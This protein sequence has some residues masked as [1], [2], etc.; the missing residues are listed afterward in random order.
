M[1]A[2]VA[3][4]LFSRFPKRT[5]QG[6]GT[7]VPGSGS[8]FSMLILLLLAALLF[9]SARPAAA[10]NLVQYASDGSRTTAYFDL[11]Q[12]F[13]N[14]KL[15]DGRFGWQN[16]S[17]LTESGRTMARVRYP[18]G[19]FNPGAV[20]QG[21]PSGGVGFRVKLGLPESD[22]M[23]ISY[24]VRFAPNFNF[25]KG[26][27]LPGLGGG[28]GN[29][30]GKIPNGSDGFSSRLMW[31]DGG[32]G[33]VYAYMPSSKE[34]GT[35]LGRGSWRFKTGVW[36]H[37]EQTLKLNTPGRSDGEVS[38]WQDGRLVFR[39]GG[40]KFRETRNLKIDLLI[41]ET[42]FGGGSPDWATPV[43]TYAD[44]ADVTVSTGN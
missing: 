27:K 3:V 22:T 36:Q 7:S 42:F 13:A 19:S 39:T 21:A 37:M 5:G 16:V 14:P 12:L 26:G 17:I 1:K 9:V 44:F 10:A 32:D 11:A 8:R 15:A 18:A 25:V 43:D 33:E 23:R 20:K 31:R 34:W 40:L 4:A 38:I 6:G 41:F 30:G 2:L 24:Y 29:T 28:K 35:S